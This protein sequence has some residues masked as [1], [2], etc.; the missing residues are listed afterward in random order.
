MPLCLQSSKIPFPIHFDP[1]L[2]QKRRLTFME[3]SPVTGKFLNCKTE[4]MFLAKPFESLK[5]NMGHLYT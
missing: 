3:L 4:D 5:V 1:Y 2:G